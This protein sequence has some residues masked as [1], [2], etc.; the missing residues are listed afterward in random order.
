MMDDKAMTAYKFV[1]IRLIDIDMGVDQ[2]K[3]GEG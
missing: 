1:I 3:A 2:V